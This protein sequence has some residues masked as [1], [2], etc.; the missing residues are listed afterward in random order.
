MSVFLE[1]PPSRL[2]AVKAAYLGQHVRGNRD[3]DEDETLQDE[4]MVDATGTR[5]LVGSSSI[6]PS[7]T[8]SL[9]IGNSPWLIVHEDFPADWEY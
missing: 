1:F 3:P 9:K 2:T 6:T 7:Q 4:P 5:M 8:D